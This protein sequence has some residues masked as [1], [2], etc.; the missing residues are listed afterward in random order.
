MSLYTTQLRWV[1]EQELNDKGRNHDEV[2]WPHVYDKLGLSDY[3]I[4]D[5]SHRQE[6]NNR[7]IRRFYFREIGFETFAMFKWH[8]R[9]TMFEIM[10]Y[11]N[12]MYEAVENVDDPL[13]DHD[14]TRTENWDV[15]TDTQ[16]SAQ[17]TSSGTANS[18][19]HGRNVF[20]DTPMSFLDDSSPNAV[21]NLDYATNVTY[22]DRTNSSTTTGSTTASNASE[23]NETGERS[24]NE[25]GRNKSQ[26]LLLKEYK[27]NILNVD[28]LV[29]NDLETLF[30][31]L[32]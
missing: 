3:P 28:V 5:E 19:M 10:P 30:M 7:I 13:S 12:L 23:G 15:D 4:Y 26:A 2:N 9:R 6:L 24:V 17:G 29:M 11:Y 22:D 1:V 18:A 25:T 16:G 21:E 14:R 20:Q 32:W 8:L 31:G 27:E